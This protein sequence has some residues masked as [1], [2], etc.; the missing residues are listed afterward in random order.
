MNKTNK[1]LNQKLSSL[2]EGFVAA[3]QEQE[4]D[5]KD[6]RKRGRKTKKENNKWTSDVEFVAN[7][8]SQ[9]II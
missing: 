6:T 3:I 1:W 2:V 8:R 9:F 4:L 7:M 5:T